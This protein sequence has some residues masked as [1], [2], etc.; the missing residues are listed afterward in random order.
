MGEEGLESRAEVDMP[1]PETPP[2]RFG[3]L[4]IM[5]AELTVLARVLL[6]THNVQN[7]EKQSTFA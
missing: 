5:C 6:F 3:V 2:E 7:Y 1:P 4:V